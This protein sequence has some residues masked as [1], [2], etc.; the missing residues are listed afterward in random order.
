MRPLTTY[1]AA[2]IF[3]TPPTRMLDLGDR[4]VA[5]RSVGS[6]PDVLFVLGWPVSGATWRKL[7]PFLVD[8]LTCHVIDL[9]GNGSSPMPTGPMTIAQH[10]DTVRRTV[11]LLG[12]DDVAVVGHDSGGLI[13]R[14]AL[15]G[16]PRVRAWG[17][18]DTEPS[19]VGWRFTSF[20]A[21]R[22]LPGL[23]AGLRR[24]AGT[25]RVARMRAVFGD[26]FADRSLMAGEFTEFFLDPLAREPGRCEGAVEVLRS[27]DPSLIAALPDLHRRIAVPVQMVW[28]E[29]DVFFPV[30][31]ARRMA[32]EFPNAR[33]RVVPDAGLF[34]HEERPEAVAEVLVPALAEGRLQG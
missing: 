23:V 22:K 21:L 32:G 7:L 24:V 2:D 10:V 11:D 29:R 15:A 20:L 1:A 6:G 28:G 33:I 26:A 31:E 3:R 17:L 19:K 14:H 9:P 25:P 12:L 13:C 34:V 4:R 27:F 18:I 30:A 16:D 5:I 8:H